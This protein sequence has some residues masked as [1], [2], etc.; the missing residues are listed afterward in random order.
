MICKYFERQ[1]K[2]RKTHNGMERPMTIPMGTEW[3]RGPVM[4]MMIIF[5]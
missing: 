3:A 1:K 5:E 2:C 4:M